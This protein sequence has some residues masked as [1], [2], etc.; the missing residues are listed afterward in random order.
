MNEIPEGYIAVP[1]SAWHELVQYELRCQE[2]AATVEA[3]RSKVFE[4]YNFQFNISTDNFTGI[5][6]TF[7]LIC[8]CFEIAKATPQQHL[9]EILNNAKIEGFKACWKH[10]HKEYGSD[11]MVKTIKQYADSIQRGEVK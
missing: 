2:L 10:V 6:Q 7:E 8:E 1:E 11:L 5:L 4:T 3:L 9:A